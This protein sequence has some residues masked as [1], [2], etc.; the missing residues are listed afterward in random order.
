[1]SLFLVKLLMFNVL[2]LSLVPDFDRIIEDAK[3]AS[4]PNFAHSE[5]W[6]KLINLL[7][8][9]VL[10]EPQVITDKKS[11]A[12][13]SSLNGPMCPSIKLKPLTDHQSSS[14]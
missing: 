3:M 6:E 12:F 14:P 4:L 10:K 5:D 8:G 11:T 9:F 7:G 2:G 1:M 13:C